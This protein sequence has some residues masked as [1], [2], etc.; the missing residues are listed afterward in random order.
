[1][2][3]KIKNK[4]KSDI[5]NFRANTYLITSKSGAILIDAGATLENVKNVMETLN[6]T[7]INAILIT[8]T[9]F[10]HIFCLDDYLKE[11]NCKAYVSFDGISNLY[12]SRLNLSTMVAPFIIKS[13]N[14]VGL[15]DG[16]EIIF[17]D[18]KVDCIST[19]GHSN[20]AMC[21]IIDE[22]MFTGDTIFNG[23]IGRLDLLD[24]RID[25]M[26]ESLA[27]I[28][29]IKNIRRYYPG[30]G[31]SFDRQNLDYTISVAEF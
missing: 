14:I 4:I 22:F 16:Q 3:H 26:R 27:K 23:C 19:S 25:D 7:A 20:S 17:E 15:D 30:H 8:H 28:S 13:K 2:I 24:S 10:D 6:I 1:M 11:F 29:K 31:L 9:H 21:F 18:L 5:D 12:D